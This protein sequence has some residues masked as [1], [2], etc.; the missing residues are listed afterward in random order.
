MLLGEVAI[1]L[2]LPLIPSTG[3]FEPDDRRRTLGASCNLKP[4]SIG[5]AD[6]G[7]VGFETRSIGDV[8]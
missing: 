7:D 6:C 5:S 2:E 3:R 4:S 8:L 1:P